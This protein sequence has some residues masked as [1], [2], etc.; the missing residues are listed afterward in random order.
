MKWGMLFHLGTNMW[1]D[2]PVSEW[3]QYSP[4]ELDLVCAAD[5]VRFDE[6]LWMEISARMK[7]EGVNLLVL[8]LG[9]A[10]QYPSHPE[11]AVKG[12]WSPDRLRNEIQRLNSMG[13]E[14]IPKL[15]FSTGHDVWL[16]EYQRMISTPEYYSVC[17]E[18]MR[19]VF[20]MF[21]NP[22]L[23]HI[24]YDEETF[25]QQK[26]YRYCAVR[27]GELWWHDLLFFVSEVERLGAR[28][29]MWS[30]YGW[31]HEAEF[32]RRMPRSV[33]QSNWDYEASFDMHRKEN[34][35]RLRFFD[36]LE[37]NG[38][39]QI[40]T[41][42]NWRHDVNFEALVA[43]CRGCVSPQRLKGFLMAPWKR[44]LPMFAGYYRK[45]VEI[46]GA[47]RR[48]TPTVDDPRHEQQ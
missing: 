18:I 40:P 1:C 31:A 5:H 38:F 23:F 46:V 29:W 34:P 48:A 22:R 15:N 13:M 44:M 9:E 25:E 43:H 10:V 2:Q 30:D 24:G 45:A 17:S 28:A 36:V 8:D 7:E 39:D 6:R 42:S 21:G 16:G 14:V 33:L 37:R 35:E 12:S 4:E 20:E 11:L 27:Q 19:D 32:V 26:R 3:G 47:T 41:G